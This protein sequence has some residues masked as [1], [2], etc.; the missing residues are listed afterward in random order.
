MGATLKKE[1]EQSTILLYRH[2]QSF[3]FPI[4]FK[5][6]ISIG[7]IDRHLSF[8]SSPWGAVSSGGAWGWGNWW[9]LH[10]KYWGTRANYTRKQMKRGFRPSGNITAMRLIRYKLA[11]L[12]S[13]VRS[14]RVKLQVEMAIWDF[15]CLTQRDQFRFPAVF[16]MNRPKTKL[17]FYM[18][19][20]PILSVAAACKSPTRVSQILQWTA[21]PD[22]STEI[23]KCFAHVHLAT[24]RATW[25]W[26]QQLKAKRWSPWRLIPR[27]MCMVS[28][29]R[30]DGAFCYLRSCSVI[31][32]F[33][34]KACSLRAFHLMSRSWGSIGVAW[35]AVIT[36]GTRCFPACLGKGC[37]FQPGWPRPFEKD[38]PPRP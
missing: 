15:A 6:G 26:R 28:P 2:L 35:E 12:H 18:T 37:G 5:N 25:W 24:V 16:P 20:C 30:Q 11:M 8:S 9:R 10:G 36:L 22:L 7:V 23:W 14:W 31:R 17:N 29:R 33:G 1:I 13:Y 3:F 32:E 27:N 4:L 38:W 21:T 34:L 19:Q